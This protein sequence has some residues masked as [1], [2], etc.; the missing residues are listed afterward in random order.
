MGVADGDYNRVT[1]RSSTPGVKI[2][3]VV[4]T[5]TPVEAA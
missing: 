5:D 3:E 1:R 2:L 4:I